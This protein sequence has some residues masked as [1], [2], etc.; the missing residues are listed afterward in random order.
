M[1]HLGAT[2]FNC[3]A[4]VFT[5]LVFC[6]CVL[7]LV[8]CK[9]HS[10]K[11][12]DDTGTT[13]AHGTDDSNT[14]SDT[15]TDSDFPLD[16]CA[17]AQQREN[18]LV[19]VHDVDNDATWQQISF[20]LPATTQ[21]AVGK[22]VFSIGEQLTIPIT[23]ANISS[24]NLHYDLL[25]NTYPSQFASIAPSQYLWLA[26]D[27]TNRSLLVGSIHEYDKNGLA[28]FGFTVLDNAGAPDNVVTFEQV[29][30]VFEALS[31]HFFAPLKFVP[32]TNA[33]LE[34][35]KLWPN[36]PWLQDVQDINYEAYA[37]AVAFGNIRFHTPTTIAD[38]ESNGTIGFTDILVF[39]E[40]PMDLTTIVSGI[41]TGT[42]QGILSHLN[43]RSASRGTPN[44]YVKIPHEELAQWKDQL[45]RMECSQNGLLIRAASVAEAEDHWDQLKPPPTDIP[46]PNYDET[47]MP[48]L[49]AVETQTA[50]QR[51]FA[52][53]AY[54]SKGANLAI[55]YQQIDSALQLQGF[56][57]PFSYYREFISQNVWTY[58]FDETP[59]ELSFEQTLKRW[60]LDEE[61]LSNTTVRQSRLIAL[62]DAIRSS[63]VSP[64]IINAVHQRIEAVFGTSTTMVRFRSS[65]NAEDSLQFNG[66]GLYE[67]TSVC[68]ADQNDS[69]T[70]GPSLCDTDQNKKRTIER[71][72]TKVW[73]STWSMKAFEER[74]WYGINHSN[75]AMGILVNTRTK[76]EL[77]N[78]V[79]F[80]TN[81]SNGENVYVV[82]AQAGELDVVSSAPGVYPESSHLE[83]LEEN[84]FSILRIN[85]SSEVPKGQ[86]VL[87]DAQLTLIGTHL[88]QL[89]NNFP[90]DGTTS[91][92]DYFMDTE[93]KVQSN[94]Q[95]IIKQIRPFPK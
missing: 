18:R 34:A 23:F 45:V 70:S 24:Y 58:D 82:N 85:N 57:I 65:S 93:W 77:A 48:A 12:Q 1:K 2:R 66:A 69:N 78:I 53:Q 21:V 64:E 10:T 25:K 87:T 33:Q 36:T 60:L 62:Q 7:G 28:A 6:A 89:Q 55:L 5:R 39:D 42:R 56:L 26:T 67:S 13:T 54:G 61:F 11:H 94:G 68:A 86:S 73:A 44:C 41:V 91:N 50:L 83:L 63:K 76:N 37:V 40:A 35:A 29:Q 92:T 16:A 88:T 46:P 32:E 31:T 59:T 72:L 75:V 43:I 20:H 14:D 15:T 30:T 47:G 95:L 71:G 17:Q 51:A 84:Q 8:G 49:S 79:A 74:H 22:Y 27:G 9:K 81:P 19:C 3:F 90:V 52:V 80:S 38:A 4:T